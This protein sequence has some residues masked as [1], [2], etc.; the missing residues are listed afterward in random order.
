MAAAALVCLAPGCASRPPSIAGQSGLQR[1]L[2]RADALVSAGCYRCLEE[3][4]TLYTNAGARAGSRAYDVAVLLA[5]RQRELGIRDS[6]YLPVAVALGRHD[7]SDRSKLLTDVAGLLPW[8]PSASNP[9]ERDATFWSHGTGAQIREWLPRLERAAADDLVASYVSLAVRCAWYLYAEPSEVPARRAGAGTPL[10]AYKLATCGPA[11]DPAALKEAFRLEPRLVE[12]ELFLGDVSMG[13]AMAL[14]SARRH[15]EAARH[16]VPTMVPATLRLGSIH[17]MLEEFDEAEREFARV[18]ALVP[19]QVDAVLGRAKALGYLRRHAEAIALLTGMITEGKWLVGDAHYWRAWNH[20]QLRDLDAAERD[21]AM[22]LRLLVNARVHALDGHIKSARE[23]WA[24]AQRAFEESLALD[25]SDCDVALSLAVTL[26][27]QA[28]WPEAATRYAGGAGCLVGRQAEL[29][30]RLADIASA[31]MDE[32]ARARFTSRTEAALGQAY[33]QEGLARLNA[34]RM[35]ANAGRRDEAM[36]HAREAASWPDR[37]AQAATL[38][39]RL[40]EAR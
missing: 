30:R 38:L 36:T 21:I 18:I 28:I 32:N 7:P 1:E 12:L 6:D 31:D 25:A 29:R 19:R 17:L 26:A 10:L 24:E 40:G 2:A 22:A 35:F 34:A 4:L 11:I 9:D 8:H 27:R 39:D 20:F 13:G 33:E 14:L 5:V 23:R 15:Y 3:A 37:A 16:L